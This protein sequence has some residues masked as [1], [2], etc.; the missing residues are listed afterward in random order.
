M[1][2]AADLRARLERFW[3]AHYD[4]APDRPPWWR[5]RSLRKAALALGLA[6]LLWALFAH[7]PETVHRIFEVPVE[8]RNLADEWDLQSEVPTTARVT[9]AGS[10][11]A[12]RL[13]D[14]ASLV[15]S[16]NMEDLQQGTNEFVLSADNID[17][18][19]GITLYSIAPREIDLQAQRMKPVELPVQ[20]QTRGQLP[21][22][23][24]L[25][26]LD[27][28][29]VRLLAPST[30]N[31]LPVQILTE[32]LVLDSIAEA[33]SITTRLNVPAPL[34]LPPDQDAEVQVTVREQQPPDQ[35]E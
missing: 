7:R 9:L 30:R 1:A 34:Q 12:F 26:P 31:D 16:L 29:E 2:S 21:D 14:P 5:R 11:Q 17:L 27:P 8:L 15:L 32:P 22:G 6:T 28:S 19:Q 35:E 24:E 10:E 13:L 33:G 18:P 25:G 4:G 20:L 3:V 23:L